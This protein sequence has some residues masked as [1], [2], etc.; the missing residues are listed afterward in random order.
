[1]RKPFGDLGHSFAILPH[2]CRPVTSDFRK[3]ANRT[4]SLV[5]VE[6]RLAHSPTVLRPTRSFATRHGFVSGR[7]RPAMSNSPVTTFAETLALPTLR[8]ITATY[9]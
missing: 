2:Q 3:T 5:V 8:P 1:L 4:P 7:F 9:A 6:V